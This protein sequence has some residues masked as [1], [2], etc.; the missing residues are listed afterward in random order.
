[1]G[2]RI[3]K[4]INLSKHLRL[5]ISKSGVG[6]SGGVRGARIS[7]NPKYGVRESVGIQGTGVYYTEQHKIK[8]NNNDNMH[9]RKNKPDLADKITNDLTDKINA[10]RDCSIDNKEDKIK[11]PAVVWR[12]III[13]IILFVASAVFIPMIV[14]AL[15]SAIVLMFTV[16]FNKQMK[17]QTQ[18]CKAIKAYEFRND[19]ECIRCCKE[20]LKYMDY[21][22]TK[23]LLE[24][25]ESE[26]NNIRVI[27]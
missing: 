26:M 6:I 2:W 11:M 5:N 15:I 27:E 22:S 20:S 14:F 1:M 23:R 12:M 19:E 7:Y 4:H 8:K 25:A 24:Q 3:N 13:T 9:Y 17:A 18:Q 21:D 16:I 10:Y